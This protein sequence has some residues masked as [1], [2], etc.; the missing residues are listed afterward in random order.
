[1]FGVGSLFV[2]GSSA[3]ACDRAFAITNPPDLTEISGKGGVEVRGTACDGDQVWLFDR[4]PYDGRLYLD[5]ERAPLEVVN[6]LWNFVDKPIGNPGAADIGTTY[7]LVALR[8]SA[9][10]N[11][12][13]ATARPNSKGEFE[14]RRLPSGCPD[15][16][17]VGSDVRKVRV[18]K[19]RL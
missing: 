16:N 11:Q 15:V 7:T 3:S 14:F 17:V 2:S 9:K 18:R 6:G 4:D 1:M 13:L 12:Q 19:A 5:T 10:C 8:A